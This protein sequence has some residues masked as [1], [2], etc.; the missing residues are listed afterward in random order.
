MREGLSSSRV[1]DCQRV[2][3]SWMS[4]RSLKEKVFLGRERMEGLLSAAIVC[5]VKAL[6]MQ[7]A[8]DWGLEPL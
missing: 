2:G 7:S 1:R 6:S 5:P 8:E 4:K 3:M